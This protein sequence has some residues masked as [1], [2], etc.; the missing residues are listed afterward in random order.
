MCLY[1]QFQSSRKEDELHEK[2]DNGTP[3]MDDLFLDI[4]LLPSEE[5]IQKDADELEEALLNG[6]I[7]ISLY[8]LAWDEANKLTNLINNRNFELVNLLNNHKEILVNKL[9]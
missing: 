2:C 1:L 8:N 5:V 7:D 6:I 4:V 9:K 3:W